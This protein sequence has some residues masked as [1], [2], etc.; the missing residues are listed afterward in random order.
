MAHVEPQPEPA[1]HPAALPNSARASPVAVEIPVEA[2]PGGDVGLERLAFFSDAVFAIAITL[3]VIDLRLPA[4][5]PNA[6]NDQLID[7]FRAVAPGVAAYALS[8]AVV[9]LYWLGHWR[10][11][12]YVVR[13][14][15]RLAM[16]NLLLL[17]LVAFIPFP[18]AVMGAQGELP[19]AVVLYAGTLAVA[20][21]VGLLTWLYAARAGLAAPGVTPEIVRYGAIRGLAVPLVMGASLLLLPIGGTTLTEFS[22]LSIFVVQPLLT[23]RFRPA[24]GI[25]RGL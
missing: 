19:A 24:G 21:L 3:L 10:R 7:A 9:G 16:I 15:Q 23:R 4:L 6:T 20:G 5:P 11:F 2:E 13:A 8:F 18:T 25:A 22:W 12:H 1:A 17:G 14:D